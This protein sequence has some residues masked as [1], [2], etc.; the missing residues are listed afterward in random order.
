MNRKLYSIIQISKECKIFELKYFVSRH[1]LK[2]IGSI[3]CRVPLTFKCNI[4]IEIFWFYLFEEK[5]QKYPSF[6]LYSDI[7]THNLYYNINRY[8]ICY[9]YLF[10]KMNIMK[11]KMY[12]FYISSVCLFI[13][14]E[15]FSLY[16]SGSLKEMSLIFQYEHWTGL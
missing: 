10:Y 4:C 15:P 12:V 1:I 9:L 16:I 13:C 8:F 5:F 6:L 2:E 11:R 3:C 14:S 7:H